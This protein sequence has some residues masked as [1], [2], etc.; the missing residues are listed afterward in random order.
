MVIEAVQLEDGGAGSPGVPLL[1]IRDEAED[2]A[3]WA[4]PEELWA[5]GLASFQRLPGP[6]QRRIFE[7]ARRRALE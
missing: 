7:V 3:Y 2:W 5:Y 6:K 4:S 1:S